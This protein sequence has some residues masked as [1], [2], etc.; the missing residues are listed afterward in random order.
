[1]G[2]AR[3]KFRASLMRSATR[4]IYGTLGVLLLGV[5]ALSGCGSSLGQRTAQSPAAASRSA[6][7][8]VGIGG[9]A[10]S[11]RGRRGG[12]RSGIVGQAVSSRCAGQAADNPGCR[13][14]PVRATI[15]ILRLP[16]RAETASVSTDYAGRFR[17][18]VPPGNYELVARTSGFL[19]LA[20][21][22]RLRVHASELAHVVVTFFPRHPLP[23]GPAAV[24]GA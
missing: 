2:E 3:M 24:G 8:S 6:S 7:T 14:R 22:M 4:T 15:E 21:G 12:Q 10:V 17:L 13:E 23:V 18:S 5:L 9:T 19:L 20:R 1:M 16:S 11:Q